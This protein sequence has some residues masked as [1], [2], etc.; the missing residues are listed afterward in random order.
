MAWRVSKG[1]RARRLSSG[2]KRVGKTKIYPLDSRSTRCAPKKR[3][4]LQTC[5]SLLEEG[6]WWVQY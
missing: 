6:L 2:C 1:D 4:R 3:L 5:Q